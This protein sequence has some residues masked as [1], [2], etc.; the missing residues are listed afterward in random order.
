MK[1]KTKLKSRVN[2]EQPK[3]NKYEPP[4]DKAVLGGGDYVR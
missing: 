4:V 3:T 1:N 2:D